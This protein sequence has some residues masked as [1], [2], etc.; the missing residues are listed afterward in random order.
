[1]F[2]SEWMTNSEY[3]TIVFKF[4]DGDLKAIPLKAITVP[5]KTTDE[6]STQSLWEGSYITSNDVENEQ[7][8]NKIYR[9]LKEYNDTTDVSESKPKVLTAD[10]Q[11]DRYFDNRIN[12]LLDSLS[13]KEAERLCAVKNYKALEA[14]YKMLQ[15]KYDNLYAKY[16]TLINSINYIKIALDKFNLDNDIEEGYE[17]IEDYDDYN[18]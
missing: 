7:V 2:I 18:D 16:E 6:N 12:S 14:D 8:L 17:E 11:T 4:A 10:N 15:D 9:D 5:D 13:K 1:M 3:A